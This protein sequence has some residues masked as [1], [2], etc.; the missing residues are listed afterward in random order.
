MPT[1]MWIVLV[2]LAGGTGWL[3]G[4]LTG[5]PTARAEEPESPQYISLDDYQ[6]L[7]KKAQK[8][9]EG[10][11]LFGEPGTDMKGLID[12]SKPLK[13]YSEITPGM[14]VPQVPCPP[15]DR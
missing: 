12:R 14:C 11:V 2:L 5:L 15:P 7:P 4:A 6:K 8:Q 1:R 13:P 3:V 9:L 10:A